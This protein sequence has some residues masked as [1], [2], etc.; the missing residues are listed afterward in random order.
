MPSRTRVC[1]VRRPPVTSGL[2]RWLI[3]TCL[4]VPLAGCRPVR[5]CECGAWICFHEPEPAP[6][7]KPL[8][9][10]DWKARTR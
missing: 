6:P 5:Y 3:L 9:V 7:D 10:A 4:L 8:T 1:P 2:L